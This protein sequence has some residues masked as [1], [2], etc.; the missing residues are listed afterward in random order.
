LQHEPR[1]EQ[2]P[3]IL[4]IGLRQRIALQP[5]GYGDGKDLLGGLRGL[6]FFVQLADMLLGKRQKRV[7]PRLGVEG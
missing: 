7:E 5:A 1:F 2:L 6:A 3:G 4:D